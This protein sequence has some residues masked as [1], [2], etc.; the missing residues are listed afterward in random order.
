MDGICKNNKCVLCDDNSKCHKC[1]WNPEV[2]ERRKKK[3]R[4]EIAME[5]IELVRQ[6]EQRKHASKWRFVSV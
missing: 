3:Q 4:D 5:R 6:D 1:G 2:F